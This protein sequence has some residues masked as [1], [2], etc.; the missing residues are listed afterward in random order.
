MRNT[1]IWHLFVDGNAPCVAVQHSGR[2]LCTEVR[3]SVE[4]QSMASYG[5]V[6]CGK[7]LIENISET[8]H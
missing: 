5:G 2:V 7:V 1:T 4:R 6:G 3:P 8:V